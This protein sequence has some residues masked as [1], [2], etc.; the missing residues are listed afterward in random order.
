LELTKDPGN[1]EWT[2]WTKHKHHWQHN[3]SKEM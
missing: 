3:I 2:R 1:K